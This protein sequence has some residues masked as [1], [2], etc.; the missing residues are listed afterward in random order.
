MN[1]IRK[2]E[3]RSDYATIFNDV[4]IFYNDT[5]SNLYECVINDNIIAC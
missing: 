2:R 5:L 1:E 4:K 3:Q